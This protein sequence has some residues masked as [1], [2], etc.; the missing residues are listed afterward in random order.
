MAG[1]GAAEARRTARPTGQA[2]AGRPSLAAEGGTRAAAA[3]DAAELPGD[4]AA[5]PQGA[6]EGGT[7]VGGGR[8]WQ[9]AGEEAARVGREELGDRLNGAS[10]R[11]ASLARGGG[12]SEGGK[13]GQ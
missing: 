3:S 5:R 11:L 8:P 2:E 6:G 9:P 13:G 12:V 1:G 10:A 7:R 4:R